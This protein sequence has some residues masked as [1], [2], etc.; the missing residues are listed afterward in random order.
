M[1]ET[2]QTKVCPLCA[3]TIK[4]A[5]KVCPHCRHWQKKWSLQNPQTIQSIGAVLTATLIFGGIAG[6]GCFFDYLFG[7]KR[8][9][10][11]YQ[12]LVTV[13]S[14]ETSFR[15]VSSNL[16]V[17]VVGVLTNES[18][19]AW[20]K[21]GVEAQFEDGGSKLIDTLEAEGDYRDLEILPHSEASFKIEGH[22]I[23]PEQDYRSTKV[24]VRTG[25][26]IHA[27]F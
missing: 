24:F 1:A 14:S 18:D 10:V 11:Q 21:I 20:R 17:S 13:V 26:D 25:E 19:F 16:T 23:H 12:S 27:P 9:F 8:D 2:E 5:A 6:V 7:P 22:A 4:A 3:E 15:M